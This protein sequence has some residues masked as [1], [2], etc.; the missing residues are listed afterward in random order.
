MLVRYVAPMIAI[1]KHNGQYMPAVICDECGGVITDAFGAMEVS[2]SAPEGA[3]AQ[4][5]H[6]HKGACD[7]AISAR[8]GAMHGSEELAVH[9]VQLLKNALSESDRQRVANLLKWSDCET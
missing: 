8:L 9:L 1:R 6:V 5:F 4:A 2:S 3:N 7:E